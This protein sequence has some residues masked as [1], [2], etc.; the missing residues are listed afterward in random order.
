MGVSVEITARDAKDSMAPA[1]CA[2]LCP[3]D[4]ASFRDTNE[5]L[6]LPLAFLAS[7]AVQSLWKYIKN[8]RGQTPILKMR[9]A[10]I[11]ETRMISHE[12]GRQDSHLP[13][14]GGQALDRG[15]VSRL[16]ETGDRPN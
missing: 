6:A 9:L 4:A 2:N 10:R 8:N 13:Q 15:R 3:S 12:N 5:T 16:G 14:A 11:R 7:F 1:L